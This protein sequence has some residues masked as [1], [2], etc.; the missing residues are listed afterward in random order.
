M[1][2]LRVVDGEKGFVADD[3]KDFAPFGLVTPEATVE[4]TTTREGD[5]PLK[6]Y[7]GKPVPGRPERVYVRQG[8]QDDVVIVDAKALTE[9]PRSPTALRSQQ[10]ADIEPASVTQI[11]IRTRES[12][13]ALSKGPADWELTAPRAEKA[14]GIKVGALLSKIAALQT[15]EFLEPSKVRK[16]ELDPPLMTIKLWQQEPSTA[17]KAAA[18][19]EPA[20][21]LTDR[22]ARL[23]LENDFRPVG[24]RLGR[25]GAARR[26][27][28]RV[29]QKPVRVPRS[30]RPDN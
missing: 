10:V 26:L 22:T 4:L 11:E 9:I 27:H 14:D 16:P 5:P 21:R 24:A 20:A 6:L 17:P 1:S 25:A 30:H 13:F 12:T 15:S 7:V 3:V 18:A 29:A 28:R 23:R 19:G 8:D 2:S